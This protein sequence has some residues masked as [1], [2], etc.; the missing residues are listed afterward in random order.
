MRSACRPRRFQAA[1]GLLRVQVRDAC[2]RQHSARHRVVGHHQAGQDAMQ[3]LALEVVR[4]EAVQIVGCVLP[5]GVVSVAVLGCAPLGAPHPEGELHAGGH[6]H[7]LVAAC[8]V[9]KVASGAMRIPM[10]GRRDADISASH[11]DRHIVQLVVCNQPAVPLRR[12][13]AHKAPVEAHGGQQALVSRPC[14]ECWP[15][16]LH[17]ILRVYE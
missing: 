11:G 4:L 1:V 2:N 12:L 8:Q 3:A 9:H 5:A 10:Q 13:H 6:P 7:G 17:I 14:P 16:Q 15:C